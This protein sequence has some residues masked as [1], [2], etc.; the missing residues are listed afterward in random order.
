MSEGVVWGVR[1]VWFPYMQS[2]YRRVVTFERV[3][4]V[5]VR[6]EHRCEL[7]VYKLYLL[8]VFKDLFG[9]DYIKIAVTAMFTIAVL[10]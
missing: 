4:V 10:W 9:F 1:W 3:Y 8:C 6:S 2:M 5:C 7:G